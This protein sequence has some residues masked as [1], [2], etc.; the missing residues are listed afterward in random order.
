MI[1]AG[2]FKNGITVELEGGLYVINDFQH[3]K[4]GKGAAFV[5]STLKNL[6]TGA[7]IERTFRPT[8]KMPR[9]HIDRRDLQ[10]L[11]SDGA[12]YHFMDNESFEQLAINASD[13][14]DAM[15]FVKEN[16]MV[17]VVEHNGRIFGIEPPMIVELA[18]T[19]T[20]PGFKGDTAQGATKPAT[21]ETGAQIKVPLF[22]EIGEIVKIDTR[23]GE[24]QGRVKE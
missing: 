16:E 22:V 21:V 8:E 11:Y 13:V 6:E 10:Y 24:Y 14:G 5:R 9:A 19:E 1:S 15:I 17:K 3:V 7:V 20:E 18:I 2:E 4:P 23:T 12:L